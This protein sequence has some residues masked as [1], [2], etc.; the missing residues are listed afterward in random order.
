MDSHATEVDGNPAGCIFNLIAE[1]ANN[2]HKTD[3]SDKRISDNGS[4]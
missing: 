3:N 4:S 1:D 2:H